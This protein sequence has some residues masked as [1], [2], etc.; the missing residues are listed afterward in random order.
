MP[1]KWYKNGIFIPF[2][3]KLWII[4]KSEWTQLWIKYASF[5]TYILYSY[6]RT[7][8]LGRR[9]GSQYV[10]VAAKEVPSGS[11]IEY[12]LYICFGLCAYMQMSNILIFK[13]P[14]WVLIRIHMISKS[15]QVHKV[16]R[17]AAC[18][19]SHKSNQKGDKWQ[20]CQRWRSR[21]HV[22]ATTFTTSHT[23][24]RLHC[25]YII[26]FSL[27]STHWKS[28]DYYYTRH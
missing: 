11:L 9:I 23:T 15:C 2:E 19:A 17:V 4:W 13:A 5:R 1:E 3:S 26:R 20:V 21:R 18:L 16:R 28:T 6:R 10:L 12:L 27:F 22:V 14:W 8:P 24:H 25:A 7:S